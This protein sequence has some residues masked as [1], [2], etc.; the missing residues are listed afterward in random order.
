MA[1]IVFRA[2]AS[3]Q[4]GAGHVMRCAALAT[5]LRQRGAQVQF[6][7]RELPGHLIDWL[8]DQGHPVRRL[9]PSA[10][11]DLVDSQRDFAETREALGDQSSAD[12]LVVDH[13]GLDIQWEHAAHALARRVMVIDDLPDRAHDCDLL[14]DQNRCV[15]WPL[16]L[17]EASSSLR[18]LMGPKYAL[19]RP[20]FAAMRA[21]SLARPRDRVRRILICFGGAD[22]ANH[23][24]AAVRA[25]LPH[26]RTLE[27]VDVLIGG[28]NP[29][30]AEVTALCRG[31]NLAV[32]GPECGVADLL[33]RADL[34]VGAGGVMSW[35]R[36]CLG[37]PTLAFGITANQVAVLEA[38][39]EG[40]YA[41]GVAHMPI[42]DV[43]AMTFWV[44]AC[45][46]SPSMLRGMGSRAAAL[47]DGQG[48]SRTADILCPVAVEFRP[49]TQD[50][51]DA[52][53]CWRNHSEV[54]AASLDDH[55]VTP[56]E[57]ALWLQAVLADPQRCLLIAEQ[58]GQPV[59]VVRFD[60]NESFATISVYRIPSL[61]RSRVGLI[62]HSI[63]WLCARRPD[64][65]RVVAQVLPQNAASLASF[66]S[67]G[68][69]P[70]RHLL[71]KEFSA[72]MWE[73]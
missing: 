44:G 38:L 23:T 32:V 59:G 19:L 64:V 69:R 57:H 31:S 10:L 16:A 17:H 14:L 7:C 61:S 43:Q 56:E 53:L 55:V 47:V 60:F 58:K 51:R 9:Q 15:P 52:L 20:E 66:E 39:L 13:Y 70:L 35:E 36:A 29:R 41:A 33:S 37:V 22:P 5:E 2:D 27:R 65:A 34:A 63:A 73:P 28:G 21:S 4:V 12:W 49:A 11:G 18:R 45:M 25:V 40:G 67:A 3:S 30:R 46:Q 8:E 26:A 1:A 50:D 68:F 42:P 71:V 6:V 24:E 62:A 72:R 54:R 48:A